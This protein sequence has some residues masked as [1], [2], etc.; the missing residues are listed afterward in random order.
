MARPAPTWAG[1]S[2]SAT[3]STT[4]I[5]RPSPPPA[6]GA[7]ARW[8]PSGICA[9]RPPRRRRTGTAR[10]GR[11]RRLSR[12]RPPRGSRRRSAGAVAGD[13]PPDVLR[14]VQRDQG[15]AGVVGVVRLPQKAEGIGGRDEAVPPMAQAGHIQLL[16]GQE[17]AVRIG[18][19][20]GETVDGV[21]VAIP[22]ARWVVRL[23]R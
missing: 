16:P 21:H 20:D 18:P 22:T 10:P 9:T 6:P 23:G 7:W 11:P 8:T 2:R 17:V 15:A 4:P 14:G 5:A 13:P 19:P 1:S 3:W 12:R